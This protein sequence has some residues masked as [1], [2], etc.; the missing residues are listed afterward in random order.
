M[1]ALLELGMGF[2]PDFTGIQNVYMSGL[3]MGLNREDIERLMPEIEAFADIGDY[4]NQP[5][6]IYSSGMQMRLALRSPLL[7]VRIF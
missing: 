5:V 2:H 6:R 4:I 1:A 7:P 3:M